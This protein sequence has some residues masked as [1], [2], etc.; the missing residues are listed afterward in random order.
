MDVKV[1][2]ESHSHQ[3]QANIF[4]QILQCLQYHHLKATMHD[5]YRY[6]NFMKKFFEPLRE[7]ALKKN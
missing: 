6:K 1:I 4:H 5:V 7:D 3:K 2:L